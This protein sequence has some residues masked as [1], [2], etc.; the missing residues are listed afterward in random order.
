MWSMI[1]SFGELLQEGIW[2]V[3]SGRR[4]QK[5]GKIIGAGKK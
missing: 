2:I 3:Q 5:R 4:M 1:L